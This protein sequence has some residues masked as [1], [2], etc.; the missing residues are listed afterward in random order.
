M[1]NDKNSLFN[2][3]CK[4]LSQKI[5]GDFCE[6]RRALEIAVGITVLAL[7]LVGGAGAATLT[8][9]DSGGENYSR[10]QDAINNASAGDTILVNSGTYFENV[11]VNKRLNLHG[12]GM[13]VV[14]AGGNGSA[15]T[16][17]ADGIILEG[18]T[19]TGGGS[20][21]GDSGIKVTSNNNMLSRNNGN[22]NYFQ[23]IFL[24]YSSNNT[25]IG[26]NATSNSQ[27]GILL[28]YS[29]NN[30]LIG[31]NVSNNAFGIYLYHSSN[32][33][34]NENNVS[35][36]NIGIEM[37]YSI[38]NMLNGN[39]AIN[40]AYGISMWDSSN[41]KIY[42]N[43]FNNTNNFYLSGT[44]INTWNTTRTP[45]TNIIGGPYLGGN[46]WAHP[47]G[48]G[49]SQTCV[50]SDRDRICDSPYALDSNNTDYQPIASVIPGDVN[51]IPGI[52]VGDVLFT[53]QFVAGVR[54]PNAA[55]IAACDVNPIPGVDV[56]DVLFVAQ[57]VAGLRILG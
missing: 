46:L 49:F 48:T 57:A 28:S 20:N 29:T 27:I 25:L 6:V 19:A 5:S 51:P 24:S 41:N 13:P 52:D 1:L 3:I 55:Q 44:N 21:N 39:N 16:L 42:N 4:E 34:Q 36:N 33:K 50:D 10:I 2:G 45:G 38:N 54:T 23:G 15:I 35:N 22:S 8:V 47:N 26:N 31:N 56:G 14:D 32:T 43:I 12:I 40:N 7:L 53:A 17:F 18:F 30:T 9:D 11:D 37:D